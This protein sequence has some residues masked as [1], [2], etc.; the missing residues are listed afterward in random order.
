MREASQGEVPSPL[1]R[2]AAKASATAVVC[3]GVKRPDARLRRFCMVGTSYVSYQRTF[4]QQ[5][6]GWKSSVSVQRHPREPE[7]PGRA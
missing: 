7:V 2:C 4:D 1:W 3:T 6:A 5:E